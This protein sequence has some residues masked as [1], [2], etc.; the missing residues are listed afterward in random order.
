MTSISIIGSLFFIFNQHYQT[1]F[2]V[3]FC[4][5]PMAFIA[6]KFY[7]LIAKSTRICHDHYEQRVSAMESND[8]DNIKTFYERRKRILVHS[9]TIQGRNWASI[10]I[11]KTAFL[12]VALI[13]FTDKNIGLT[14]GQAI[15]MYSY[16]NQFLISLMSIPVGMEIYSRIKDVLNRI[17]TN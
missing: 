2:I 5:I 4:A 1:A 8:E 3:I 10:N 14:Q 11:T 6:K 15:S 13:V 7:R 17:Q 12:I 16:I 9:S